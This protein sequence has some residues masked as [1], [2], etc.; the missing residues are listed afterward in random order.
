MEACALTE[1]GLS[2]I[3][4]Q[5]PPSPEANALFQRLREQYIAAGF[6]NRKNWA[7][8]PDSEDEEKVYNELQARGYLEKRNIAMWVLSA[9]AHAEIMEST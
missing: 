3:L 7:F 8:G 5:L 9:A 1:D 2:L 6:P 4:R